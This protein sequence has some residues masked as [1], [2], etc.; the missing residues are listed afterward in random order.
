MPGRGFGSQFERSSQVCK[1]PKALQKPE[2]V[3]SGTRR[4]VAHYVLSNP[5][6]LRTHSFKAVLGPK[7][8]L[9]KA[10]G[11]FLMLRARKPDNTPTASPPIRFL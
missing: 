3:G 9:H 7:T 5:K 6:A 10:F 11:L 4:Y 8:L 2:E 1:K